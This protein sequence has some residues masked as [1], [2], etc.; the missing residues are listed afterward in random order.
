MEFEDLQMDLFAY[1]WVWIAVVLTIVAALILLTRGPKWRDFL[2]FGII[3]IG[4]GVAFIT[5]H[6][7]ESPLAGDAKLIQAEIGQG[8]PVLLEFQSPY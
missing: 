3:V 2:S 5:L 4:L 6:P 7:R 1:F 8:T